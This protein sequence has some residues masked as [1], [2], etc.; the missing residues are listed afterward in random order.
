MFP[1]GTV[2]FPAMPLALRIFEPRYVAMLTEVLQ[3][4]VPE[5]GVVLI[6][7]GLESGGGDQRFSTGTMARVVQVEPQDGV[8][9]LVAVGTRRVEVTRWLPEDPY[10]RAEVEDLELLAWDD[11]LEGLLT[12][13]E[14]VVRA[15]VAARGDGPG[16]WP[17]DVELSAETVAS[18]WQLAAMAPLGPLDQLGLLRSASLEELLT[19][20][21]RATTEAAE[22]RQAWGTGRDGL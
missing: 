2:L 8:I 16:A 5:L 22:V 6:E 12:E 18:A 7:R 17:A 20:V 21:L 13:T 3:G 19:S 14:A 4:D 10:P 15:E 11:S 9:G 1:L